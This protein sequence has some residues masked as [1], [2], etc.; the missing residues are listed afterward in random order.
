MKKRKEKE[1][2][3]NTKPLWFIC[4]LIDSATSKEDY[5]FRE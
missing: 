3:Y 4:V 1:E 5:S 2:R